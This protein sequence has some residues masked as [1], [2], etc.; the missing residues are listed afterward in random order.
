VAESENVAAARRGYEIW[1]RGNLEEILANTPEDFVF[2]THARI[3]GL[4]QVLRGR[5]GARELFDS[6]ISEAWRGRLVMEP[7]HLIDLGGDRVL[8]LIT[9][10]AT[11]EGSGVPVEL[12]YAHLLTLR[13]GL[14]VRIE[15]F[16]TWEKALEA[17]GL[18]A[19]P[20]GD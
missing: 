1:N 4:P 9:F 20:P 7:T 3:P 10:T 11:G 17:A 6:W 12:R 16:L 15:G 14:A 18:E 2:D 8:A 19:I 13:D 5:E